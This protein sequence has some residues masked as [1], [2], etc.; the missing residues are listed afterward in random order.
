MM[1]STERPMRELAGRAW[2]RSGSTGRWG[3]TA[4][5][6]STRPRLPLRLLMHHQ[7]VLCVLCTAVRDVGAVAPVT[8]HRLP[9]RTLVLSCWHVLSQSLRTATCTN[10]GCLVLSR[11]LRTPSQDTLKKIS[12]LAGTAPSVQEFKEAF[13][14]SKALARTPPRL[15]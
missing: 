9:V 14:G 2:A 8:K 15:Y 5:P 7:G 12:E 13:G 3:S 11:R 1:P 10:R 6:L 4:S